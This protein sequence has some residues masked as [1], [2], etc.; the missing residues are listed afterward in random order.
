MLP[1][2]IASHV[3]VI[4]ASSYSYNGNTKVLS[5]NNFIAEFGCFPFFF[6][7]EHEPVQK[8]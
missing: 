8:V 7:G 1:L 6:F 2:P 5:T 4:K 3:N